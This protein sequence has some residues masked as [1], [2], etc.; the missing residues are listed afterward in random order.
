MQIAKTIYE[1]WFGPDP[2]E[3]P[4]HQEIPTVRLRTLFEVDLNKQL[5]RRNSSI[6]DFQINDRNLGRQ[7]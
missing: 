3:R 2:V 5:R 6:R 4:R 1:W 7:D